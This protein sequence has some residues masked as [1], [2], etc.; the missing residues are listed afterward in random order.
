MAEML[1]KIPSE[2]RLVYERSCTLTY[3]FGPPSAESQVEVCSLLFL[4]RAALC[5]L[6]AIVFQKLLFS[7]F[8]YVNVRSIVIRSH[9]ASASSHRCQ[10]WLSLRLST[11]FSCWG[12]KKEKRKQKHVNW[13]RFLP[14]RLSVWLTRARCNICS[15]RGLYVF[16]GITR[17]AQTLP[18]ERAAPS[19]ARM[20]NHTQGHRL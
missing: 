1:P 11:S 10:I 13:P 4:P 2:F 9:L 5:I 6:A 3:V 15:S 12:G 20:Q 17:P 18:P 14:T 16:T 7:L 8:K 19:H